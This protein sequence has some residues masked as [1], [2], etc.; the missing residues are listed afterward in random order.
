MADTIDLAH[1]PTL[2]SMRRLGGSES[3]DPE[4]AAFIES[5]E[6]ALER[7]SRPKISPPS[8]FEGLTGFNSN[9]I[10]GFPVSMPTPKGRAASDVLPVDHTEG[11]RLDYLHFSV[12][13]SKKRRTAMFVGVNVDGGRSVNID[14]A[15]DKWFLDGRIPL[16]AQIGE[17]LYLDN[18]LD[19]GHLVRREDPNWGDTNEAKAANDMT[20]HFTNC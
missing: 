12:V 11:G 14:R 10:D 5:A 13:M 6:D 1:R 18:L 2:T 19:R 7:A 4:I 15:N 8:R 17:E 16:E 20:F 9:F 3:A